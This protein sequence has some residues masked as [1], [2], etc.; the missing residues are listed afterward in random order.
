[1]KPTERGLLL[2]LRRV[3]DASSRNGMDYDCS[4]NERMYTVLR[5]LEAL[6]YVVS[7][8]GPITYRDQLRSRWRLTDDGL[9]L[10]NM[11]EREAKLARR[12]A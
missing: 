1:M 11:L 3:H 6:D 9:D 5:T 10:L 4:H 2:D 7:V 12:L 8:G